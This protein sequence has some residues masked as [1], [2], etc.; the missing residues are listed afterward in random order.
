MTDKASSLLPIRLISK[1]EPGFGRG[2]KELGIPTANVSRQN[3]DCAIEFDAL[4]CGIYWGFARIFG[5]SVAPTSTKTP[6]SAETKES[7]ASTSTTVS[8]HDSV[9]PLCPT[10]N[11]IYP[12]A[13]SIGFNPYY[14]NTTK[15]VEPHLIAPPDDPSR[16][17]SSCG[18]TQFGDLYGMKIRLSI[19]GYMRPELPFEGLEKLKD[20]IKAD[21]VETE[22]LCKELGG[23]GSVATEESLWVGG[24]DQAC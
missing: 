19:V 15:A 22:R 11:H 9:V 3:L 16:H 8:S 1:I 14:A 18:E 12:A 21:I 10:S 24:T 2:S 23:D 13:I 4:P 7:P 17:V 6:T 20:A 5:D